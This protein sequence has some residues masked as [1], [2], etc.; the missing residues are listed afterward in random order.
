M[1]TLLACIVFEHYRD[2]ILLWFFML[3]A[4]AVYAAWNYL[5][6]W[7]YDKA[8]QKVENAKLKVVWDNGDEQTRRSL[9]QHCT[10]PDE[11]LH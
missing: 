7:R 11:W 6:V 2:Q 9:K 10:I 1:P 8:I 4:G 5:Q 3:I